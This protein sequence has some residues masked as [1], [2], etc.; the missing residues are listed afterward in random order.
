MAGRPRDFERKPTARAGAATAHGLADL[1]RLAPPWIVKRTPPPP[2]QASNK[3][4]VSPHDPNQLRLVL[5]IVLT[6]LRARPPE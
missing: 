5:A 4:P 2:P 6:L 3:S 1:P